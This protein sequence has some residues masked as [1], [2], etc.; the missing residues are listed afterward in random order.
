[1]EAEIRRIIVQGHPRQKV[2]ETPFQPIAEHSGL[3]LMFQLC[4]ESQIGF[5][6][7]NFPNLG[8][9][10]RH[11]LRN[12]QCKKSSWSSSNGRGHT[13]DPELTQ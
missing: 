13:Q 5:A 8:E 9:K 1:V 3:Y 2:H 11:Y 4:G 7:E 10:V 6:G 12:N